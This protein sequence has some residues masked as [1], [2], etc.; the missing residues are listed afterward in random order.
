ML[1]TTAVDGDAVAFTATFAPPVFTLMFGA[2]TEIFAP[3]LK[4]LTFCVF[5]LFERFV[6]IAVLLEIEFPGT[7][8][9]GMAGDELDDGALE[10]ETG[11]ELDELDDGVELDE[12]EE[13][14][15]LDEELEESQTTLVLT[16]FDALFGLVKMS[17]AAMSSAVMWL[18][19]MLP[20][21]ASRGTVYAIVSVW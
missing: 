18:L 20:H 9:T 21:V 10:L 16:V 3:A 13:G 5:W 2:P 17:P 7:V 11:V 6:A 14:A 8:T 1:F 12:L 4:I 15:E 19:I